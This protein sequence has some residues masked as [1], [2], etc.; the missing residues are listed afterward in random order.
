M[1]EKKRS[2]IRAV[3]MDNLRGL[4]GIGRMDRI[5]KARIRKLCGVSK[6]VDGRIDECVPWGFSHVERMA[7]DRIAKRIYVGECAGSRSG[8]RSMD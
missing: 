6:V 8:G 2:R 7:K 3:Q 1:E 5:P 4:L